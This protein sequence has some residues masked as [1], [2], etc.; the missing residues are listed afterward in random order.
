MLGS[1]F[2]GG[3][4]QN[5]LNWLKLRNMKPWCFPA[6]Q[7]IPENVHC[8]FRSSQIPGKSSQFWKTTFQIH[9]KKEKETATSAG[10]P[11][12]ILQPNRGPHRLQAL[13]CNKAFDCQTHLLSTRSSQ[14]NKWFSKRIRMLTLRRLCD[15]HTYEYL[16][17]LSG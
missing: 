11:M 5:S 10:E 13:G 4:T 6:E 12:D 8:K 15:L 14:W 17:R 1:F 2:G 16:L 7:R 9:R 3:K